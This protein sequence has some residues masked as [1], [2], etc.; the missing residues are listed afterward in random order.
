MRVSSLDSKVTVAGMSSSNPI[1]L[2]VA[3]LSTSS[4]VSVTLAFVSTGVILDRLMCCC[5]CC[6]FSSSSDIILLEFGYRQSRKSLFDLK[7]PKKASPAFLGGLS[8]VSVNSVHEVYFMSQPNKNLVFPHCLHSVGQAIHSASQQG[9]A[10]CLVPPPLLRRSLKETSQLLSGHGYTIRYH[11]HIHDDGSSHAY[12][13]VSWI[14]HCWCQVLPEGQKVYPW[15]SGAQVYLYTL[16]LYLHHLCQTLKVGD[17]FWAVLIPKQ[18]CCQNRF[19]QVL[20]QRG[21]GIIL[22]RVSHECRV[23]AADV[24]LSL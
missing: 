21:L 23:I 1:M 2:L 11:D 7:P 5:C 8:F 12:F 13:L 15:P 10:L 14:C 4:L 3:S 19:L 17:V 24:S 20:K 16:E 18:M 6:C 22:D 9:L